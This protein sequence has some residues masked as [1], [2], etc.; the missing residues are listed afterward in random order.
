MDEAALASFLLGMAAVIAL[1]L[2]NAFFVAAEF[3]LV[4]ARQTR[5]ATVV[6]AFYNDDL[7]AQAD[8]ENEPDRDIT[9]RTVL[10]RASD[11]IEGRFE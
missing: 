4:A 11:R 9:L 1:M 8:P 10:E 7:L 2:T 6:N 5:I 3:A